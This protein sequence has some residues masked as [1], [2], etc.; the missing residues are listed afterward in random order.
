MNN[1]YESPAY[2][3]LVKNLKLDKELHYVPDV[4][5]EYLPELFDELYPD[6]ENW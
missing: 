2:Y 6:P 1:A 3:D 5:K 4:I